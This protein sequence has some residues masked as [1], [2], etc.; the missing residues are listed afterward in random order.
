MD[1]ATTGSLPLALLGGVL[2]AAFIG[3]IAYKVIKA[4]NK[5]RTGG[6]SP[7]GGPRGNLRNK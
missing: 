1:A 2:L 7:G 4:K 5:P 3:F 6:G